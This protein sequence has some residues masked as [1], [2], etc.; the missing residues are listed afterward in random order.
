MSYSV[1]HDLKDVLPKAWNLRRLKEVADII[2]SNVDKLTVEGEAAV[3]LCNY[4]DTYKN[5]KITTKIEFMAATAT[6]AQIERLSL[7]TGDITITKDSE[8]PWDIAVPALV[9]EEIQRL[10]SR[11]SPIRRSQWIGAAWMVDSWLGLFAATKVWR[12]D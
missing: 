9:A 6:T 5:E 1:E 11:I 7:R 12:L 3:R 8:S 4:V 10:V 2:P